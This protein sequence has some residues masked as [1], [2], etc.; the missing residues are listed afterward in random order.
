[1]GAAASAVAARKI[2]E[3]R[4]AAKKEAWAVSQDLDPEDEQDLAQPDEL[5]PWHQVHKII[6]DPELITLAKRKHSTRNRTTIRYLQH[7][8]RTLKRAAAEMHQDSK[9]LKHCFLTLCG[10]EGDNKLAA[11]DNEKATKNA[12]LT[13]EQLRLWLKVM[14]YDD[15]PTEVEVDDCFDRIRENRELTSREVVGKKA[16]LVD[17]D[18]F[19]VVVF[20][21]YLVM[22]V[23]HMRNVFTDLMLI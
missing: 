21:F 23:K 4:K 13:R 12:R 14:S 1:M 11:K 5:R 16:K 20:D 7:E 6:V 3:K 18:D 19:L 17:F 22:G 15:D 2:A 9:F 8:E 10:K